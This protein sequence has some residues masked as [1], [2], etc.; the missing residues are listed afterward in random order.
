MAIYWVE[1]KAN[2]VCS[3][4]A[5]KIFPGESNAVVSSKEATAHIA[6]YIV[7]ASLKNL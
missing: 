6:R 2:Q 5:L 1:K 3:V 7:T 4:L